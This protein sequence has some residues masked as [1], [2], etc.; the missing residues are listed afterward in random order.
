MTTKGK[1]QKNEIAPEGQTPDYPTTLPCKDGE[2]LAPR[3]V[4]ADDPGLNEA[5]GDS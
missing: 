1:G 3:E 5:L 2:G 4:K